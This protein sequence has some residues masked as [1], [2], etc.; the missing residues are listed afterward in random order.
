MVAQRRR[1][2]GG[3]A[4]PVA[5]WRPQPRHIFDDAVVGAF[6]EMPQAK[7]P[8]GV[9][10]VETPAPGVRIG[11]IAEVILVE[12]ERDHRRVG[13][14]KRLVPI[15]KT[16]GQHH[17]SV[18]GGADIA[19]HRVGDPQRPPNVVRRCVYPGVGVRGRVEEGRHRLKVIAR[20]GVEVISLDG[21]GAR[22]NGEERDDQDAG[23]EHGG[24]IC[25]IGMPSRLCWDSIYLR[26]QHGKTRSHNQ[27]A[28]CLPVGRRV[29][30]L[31]LCHEGDSKPK[32]SATSSGD[33]GGK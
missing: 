16:V 15:R 23:E 31:Q 26:G 17:R 2:D 32:G 19:E 24:A 1:C 21:R 11:V 27:C 22:E 25:A 13:V 7:G 28:P 4:Q 14:G 9:C 10:E 12:T 33:P 5:V 29:H 18:V 30:R 20:V 8:F 6:T 3:A